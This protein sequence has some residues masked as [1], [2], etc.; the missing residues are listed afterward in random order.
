M[1][2]LWLAAT[3]L[4]ATAGTA[5][6][7]V[8]TRLGGGGEAREASVRLQEFLA[9]GEQYEMPGQ[10]QVRGRKNPTGENWN[11]VVTEQGGGSSDL[12]PN[13]SSSYEEA[14]LSTSMNGKK[15]VVKAKVAA[16]EEFK[17]CMKD[18]SLAVI[19]LHNPGLALAHE[20]RAAVESASGSAASTSMRLRVTEDG[21]T[22]QVTTYMDVLSDLLQA[23]ERRAS[24][25]R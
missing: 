11:V 13:D 25:V 5:A 19:N 21:P 10:S 23:A 4:A 8:S 1:K 14:S 3:V 22:G 16:Q 6:A 17:G 2:K 15:Y 18:V 24:S 7:D 9:P 12:C 20:V